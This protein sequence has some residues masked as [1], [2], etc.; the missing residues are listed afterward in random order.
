[1]TG[2]A[3]TKTS[4]LAHV[5]KQTRMPATAAATER[6]SAIQPQENTL[7]VPGRRWTLEELRTAARLT[8]TIDGKQRLDPGAVAAAVHMSTRQVQ[9]WLSG[10]ARPSPESAR[11][12]RAALLPRTEVL[13]RQLDDAR[14]AFASLAEVQEHQ[15]SQSAGED[16]PVD[17]MSSRMRTWKQRGFL[18]PHLVLV[19][20]RPD[21]GVTRTGVIRRDPARLQALLGGGTRPPASTGG[22][23]QVLDT[24]RTSNRFEAVLVRHALMLDMAW[25]RVF[26]NPQLMAK[27]HSDGWLSS[28]P[29]PDLSAIARSAGVHGRRESL[30]PVQLA[31][32]VS[33]PQLSLGDVLPEA[34][35]GPAPARSAPVKEQEPAPRRRRAESPTTR[36]TTSTGSVGGEAAAGARPTASA[37]ARDLRAALGVLAVGVGAP[38]LRSGVYLQAQAS[39]LLLTAHD[40]DIEAHLSLTLGRP[41]A[42]RLVAV[43]D[44]QELQTATSRLVAALSRAASTRA[45]HS[46]AARTG[47]P[48][49]PLDIGLVEQGV[50]LGAGDGAR[51]R[52]QVITP[53]PGPPRVQQEGDLQEVLSLPAGELATRARALAATST[54]PRAGVNAT[55]SPAPLHCVNIDLPEDGVVHLTSTD[56]TRLSDWTTTS[57]WAQPST[58][59][60]VP[61]DSLAAATRALA[62]LDPAAAVTLTVAADRVQLR[63]CPPSSSEAG[64]ITCTVTIACTP[65]RGYPPVRSVPTATAPSTQAQPGATSRGFK[66]S[67]AQ[68]VRLVRAVR[69][70]VQHDGSETVVQLHHEVGGKLDIRD[71]TGSS[72]M[73]LALS[74]RTPQEFRDV[75]GAD[76]ARP[77]ASAPVHTGGSRHRRPQAGARP[78]GAGWKV[79]FRAADL[80]HA[81]STF[82]GG[83]VVSSFSDGALKTASAAWWTFSPDA[84]TLHPS[85]GTLSVAVTPTRDGLDV[86]RDSDQVSSAGRDRGEPIARLLPRR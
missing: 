53:V 24:L 18:E 23:W 19:I 26:V 70:Q 68:V 3:P 2:K 66:L 7:G 34:V 63:M 81:L 20:T 57:T 54:Y 83:V 12:L 75:A 16:A 52:K 30:L 85:A 82:S 84:S 4:S 64:A 43:V 1:M 61:A 59:V 31:Q 29:L 14:N 74:E 62:G 80:A 60:L 73:R 6:S 38:G 76:T 33:S 13:Q 40:H 37:S 39:S 55:T 65:P 9:R 45:A 49:V 27:G 47:G 72:L 77:A 50:V 22:R 79:S 51:R 67:G 46:G 41:R 42:S 5:G 11:R 8:F 28:A 71:R 15:R 86:L 44:L 17:S 36:R 32:E 56:G 25:W 10:Q 21:L 69:A 48:E 58:H 78:D 35:D